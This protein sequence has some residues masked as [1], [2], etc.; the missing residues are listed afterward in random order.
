MHGGRDRITTIYREKLILTTGFFV[1]QKEGS[2]SQ[3]AKLKVLRSKQA[4]VSELQAKA[5]IVAVLATNN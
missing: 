2:A 4:G 5:K 3:E 1:S